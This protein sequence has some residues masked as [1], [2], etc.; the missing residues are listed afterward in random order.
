MLVN[1]I[2]SFITSFFTKNVQ[3]CGGFMK[4]ALLMG[5]TGH[6]EYDDLVDLVDISLLV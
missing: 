5:N 4:H 6:G 3:V 1:T 2:I